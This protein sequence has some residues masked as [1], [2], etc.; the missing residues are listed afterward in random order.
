MLALGVED[1]ALRSNLGATY[2]AIGRYDDAI[3][4]YRRALARD[5]GNVAIR[6][7]LALAYYKTSRMQDAAR[8]A[9]AVALA[10]PDNVAARLLLADCLFRLGQN[11]RVVDLLQPLAG[12]T[13]QDRA[14]SYLLGMALMKRRGGWRRRRP[15]STACCATTRPRHTCSSR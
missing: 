9:E 12:R 1:P 14:V 3:D 8:E 10:Q 4:Q 15:R 6:R 11:G 2:A 5:E 13:S 7:N